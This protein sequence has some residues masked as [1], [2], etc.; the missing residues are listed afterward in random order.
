MS[1]R[2]NALDG[3]NTD[4]V[5]YDKRLDAAIASKGTS[6]DAIY[7]VVLDLCRRFSISGDLLEFG[8]GAG[9]LLKRLGDLGYNG[10]IT[11]IDILPRPESL[12]DAVRWLHADLNEAIPARDRSFDVILASEVIEHLENPRAVFR[13]FSRVLRRE[14]RLI[15]TTPNQESIRSIAGLLFGGHFVAFLGDCYPAHITAL[16]RKDFQR[17]CSETGFSPPRFYYTNRGGIPK[18]PYILWQDL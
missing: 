9:N 11:A 1:G 6:S 7:A 13:E 16:L 10:K 3:A 2:Q 12:P 15:L 17:I 14:G 4:I 5:L 8:A 18:L